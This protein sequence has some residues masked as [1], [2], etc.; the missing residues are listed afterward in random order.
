MRWLT[1][2]G[3]SLLRNVHIARTTAQQRWTEISTTQNKQLVESRLVWAAMALVMMSNVAAAQQGGG[4]GANTGICGMP[5]GQ[6]LVPLVMNVVSGALVI[7]GVLMVGY[8][9]LNITTNR[10]RGTSGRTVVIT[11]IAALAIGL[12]FGQI[13]AWMAGIMGTNLNSLGLQCI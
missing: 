7:G 11:G 1:T 4:G 12:V 6:A 9:L 5:G 10:R 8:G 13:P 3:R 2:T